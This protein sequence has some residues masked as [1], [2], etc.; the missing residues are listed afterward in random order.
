M[1]RTWLKQPNLNA[2]KLR[3]KIE[4]ASV[5]TLGISLMLLII[6]LTHY[7][8]SQALDKNEFEVSTILFAQPL[9]S[10]E[11]REVKNVLRSIPGIHDDII[12]QKKRAVCLRD[13]QICNEQIIIQELSSKNYPVQT[14]DLSPPSE[15]N[16][17]YSKPHLL[18]ISLRNLE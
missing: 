10:A 6:L 11:K 8:T 1:L 7:A 17:S 3:K 13:N 18:G 15:S 9:D 16:H 4:I 12:V 5:C 14:S 2:M